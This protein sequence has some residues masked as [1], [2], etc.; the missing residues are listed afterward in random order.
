MNFMKQLMLLVSA[1]TAAAFPGVWNGKTAL[2]EVERT[3]GKVFERYTIDLDVLTL[4][5]YER[6]SYAVAKR[7]KKRLDALATNGDCRRCWFQKKHCVCDQCPPLEN[8]ETLMRSLSIK[9]IFVL[10]HHKEIGLAV[11]TTKYILSTFPKSCKLV[12]NGI[13]GQ[14]Q[15]SMAELEDVMTNESHRCLVLFP[16]DD[17][18]PISSAIRKLSKAPGCNQIDNLNVVIIDGTWNQARK[19]HVRLPTGAQRVCLSDKAIASLMN[20]CSEGFQL[21]RHPTKWRE[22]STLEALRLFLNDLC[23]AI[24]SDLVTHASWDIL[25]DYQTTGDKSALKQLGPPRIKGTSIS[26]Q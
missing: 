16:S 4:N 10:T 20:N 19:M 14:F 22:I 11:D 5:S 18:V 8:E 26:L 12:V 6:E 17:A 25:K 3:I 21:R 13:S 24:D 7:L 9:N 23:M 2:D 15:Q 1:V